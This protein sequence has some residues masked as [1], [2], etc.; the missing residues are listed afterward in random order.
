MSRGSTR[1][2]RL[3]L[4][5]S[6]ARSPDSPGRRRWACCRQLRVQGVVPPADHVHPPVQDVPHRRLPGLDA[7]VA[8]HDGAVHDPAD[9]GN[10]LQRLAGGGDGAVAGGGADDLD[11]RP[12]LH[13][14]ADRAVVGVEAAH[15]HGDPLGK[16]Q[17]LRPG[18]REAPRGAIG[19]VGLVEEPVA[20]RG[21]L[22]IEAGEELL[23]RQAAP[24]VG[25]ERLVAGGADAALD[26]A[27]ARRLRPGRAGTKSASST[28]LAA[29]SKTSGATLRQR[30][31]FDQ[32]H[33]EE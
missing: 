31:T 18:S 6:R 16:A 24:G 10:V 7:V 30:Q 12:R 20:Q 33:S 2:V 5:Q 27:R 22:R 8:G 23:G 9:A 21:Q 11:E 25:V 19:G 13:P 4:F 1:I 28:Q 17:L 32:N 15:G 29:A 14:R 3:P 26:L